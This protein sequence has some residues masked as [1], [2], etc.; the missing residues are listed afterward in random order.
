MTKLNGQA[1]TRRDYNRNED[2]RQHY[3]QGICVALENNPGVG[4]KKYSK[5]VYC[6]RCD[7]WMLQISMMAN[8]KCPCCHFR[9]RWKGTSNKARNNALGAFEGY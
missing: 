2:G 6:S 3:C 9:P 4:G 8:E 5:H 1:Q 7:K